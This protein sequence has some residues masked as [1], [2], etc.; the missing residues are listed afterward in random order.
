MRSK[1]IMGILAILVAFAFVA[2]AC[3][4]DDDSGSSS[5][6]SDT[7]SESSS[8][9][10]SDTSS[11][12]ADSSSD[13]VE[14]TTTGDTR[15]TPREEM[16]WVGVLP[17]ENSQSGLEVDFSI[18]DG[19][20]IGV[21]RVLQVPEATIQTEICQPIVEA[22]GGTMDIVDAN[23]DPTLALQAGETFLARGDDAIW[24]VSN[25]G[26]VLRPIIDEMNALGKP[27]VGTYTF[28]QPGSIDIKEHDWG[29]T[30]LLLQ[31]IGYEMDSV[32]KLGIAILPGIETLDVRTHMVDAVIGYSYPDI[33]VVEIIGDGTVEGFRAATEA[34]LQAHP[35]IKA[36][37][38]HWDVPA[39]GVVQALE[40]AGKIGDVFVSSYTGDEETGF[41]M[42]RQGQIQTT[43]AAA[44]SQIGA[45]ACEYLALALS[46]VPLPEHTLMTATIIQPGQEPPASGTGGYF[47]PPP[48]YKT[49]QLVTQY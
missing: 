14:L 26:A 8:D 42:M 21:I 44:N 34:A 48:I 23:F 47:N 28:D 18:F 20:T 1:K 16:G 40:D 7:S 2:A 39:A 30:P 37:Y 27:F 31:I 6:A 45:I 13:T 36:I 12:S 29:V 38:S 15:V 22:N 32:G 35:D 24:N 43:V 49:R 46:G 17:A 25:S 41:E 5:A 4:G 9:S 10:S 33:E 19:K 11:D 3:G